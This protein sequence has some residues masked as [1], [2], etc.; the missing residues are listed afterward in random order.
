MSGATKPGLV[1]WGVGE[2][3]RRNLIPAIAASPWSLTGLLSRNQALIETIAPP[4]VRVYADAADMLS[5]ANVAAVLLAGPNGVHYEQAKAVLS[6]GKAAL[7]EKSFCATQKQAVELVNLAERHG[8]LV[9]ECFG[10]AFHPQFDRLKTAL[11]ETS[12]LAS[13]TARFGFPFRD[14]ADIRYRADLA[15]GAL[16]DAGAYCLSAMCRLV[17]GPAKVKWARLETAKGYAVDT[18]GQ[19]V[20]EMANGVT[21]FCDWGFGRAY[22]NEVEAWSA[23]TSLRTERIFAKPVELQTVVRI[24]HQQGN[25]VEDATV[26]AGNAFAGLLAAMAAARNDA[27]LQ[28]ALRKDILDQAALVHDV[29]RLAGF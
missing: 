27:V 23:S 17:P 28:R 25:L 16:L 18:G 7:V 5:D 6:V 15:G 21:G 8:V 11:S 4:G 22:R 19:A 3:A 13:L 24:I 12:E 20:V 10:Y 26:P 14:P 2:H 9:A 29:R 1:V